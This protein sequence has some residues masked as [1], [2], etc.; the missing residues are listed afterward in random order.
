MRDLA[1][2]NSTCLIALERIDRLD[3]LRRSFGRVVIPPEVQHE[4][5][6][7]F[8]WL[9]VQQTVNS[10]LFSALR[11]SLGDGE[12]AAIALAVELPDAAI[13]LDDLKARRIASRLG[14]P[15]IGTVGLILRCKRLGLLPEVSPIIY[16][17]QSAGFHLSKRLL[18]QA[19]LSAGEESSEETDMTTNGGPS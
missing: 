12:S 8:S 7:A 17:L 14:I 1:V 10:G 9:E 11:L 3:L 16:K 4:I 19:L 18:R 15:V 5:G 6:L 2:S 13:L